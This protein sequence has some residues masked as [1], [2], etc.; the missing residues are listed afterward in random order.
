VKEATI[1]EEVDRIEKNAQLRPSESQVQIL[2]AI[3]THYTAPA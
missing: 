3:R 1:A 2:D